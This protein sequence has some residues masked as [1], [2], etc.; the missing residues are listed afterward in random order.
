MVKLVEIKEHAISNSSQHIKDNPE[1]ILEA[2]KID[3]TT[4]KEIVNV[5]SGLSGASLAAAWASLG[6]AA[7]AASVKSLLI[8]AG[9]TNPAALLALSTVAAGA[10]AVATVIAGG[11]VAYTLAK[12]ANRGVFNPPASQR[13]VMDIVSLVTKRDTALSKEAKDKN[14]I[15]SLT[16]KIQAKSKELIDI[17]YKD[18]KSEKIDLHTYRVY[19]RIAEKG[20]LGRLSNMA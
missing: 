15:A 4:T 18:Y 6:T 10:V 9:F 1:S 5:S 3:K 17:S 8:A 11:K 14:K 2:L 12:D 16:L 20:V 19:M 13:L 7:T